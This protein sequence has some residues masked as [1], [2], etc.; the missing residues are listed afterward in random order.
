MDYCYHCID[1]AFKS[2]AIKKQASVPGIIRYFKNICKQLPVKYTFPEAG[3]S[4]VSL[5]N[6]V[7]REIIGKRDSHQSNVI[8]CK[9][10]VA[11]NTS[12]HCQLSVDSL[13][14]VVSSASLHVRSM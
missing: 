11:I 9:L 3:L 12:F 5:H 6:Y 10:M 13:F 8:T 7:C 4:S 1:W 2:G 14:S